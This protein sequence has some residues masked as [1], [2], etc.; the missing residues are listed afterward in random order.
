MQ[1]EFYNNPVP[2][3]STFHCGGKTPPSLAIAESTLAV[4]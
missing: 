2:V 4:S 3:S 1:T